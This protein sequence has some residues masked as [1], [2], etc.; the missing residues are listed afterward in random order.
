MKSVLV[1]T[2]LMAAIAMSKPLEKRY[3]V[4][5]TDIYTITVTETGG[6]AAGPTEAWGHWGWGQSADPAATSST[7]AA[8]VAAADPTEGWG[9][10]GGQSADPAA[11]STTTAAA[12]AWTSSSSWAPEA[13][14]STPEAPVN[15]QTSAPAASTW[16]SAPAAATSS[17]S[18]P[19]SYAQ[20]ILDQHNNHRQNHSAQALVWDDNMANI[21]QQ[22]A[23]SCVY[24]HNT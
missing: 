9:S 17:A 2:S 5:E 15:T 16:S 1:A 18:S 12:A 10:W 22:I 19:N 4:T 20:A 21:A 13:S 7:T 23:E 3:Y 11:T 14:A 8:A 24:A 6:W